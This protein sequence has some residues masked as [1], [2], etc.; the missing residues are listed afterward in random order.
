MRQIEENND[1]KLPLG[2]AKHA[3][4]GKRC[5]N[6]LDHFPAAIENHALIQRAFV[7]DFTGFQLRWFDFTDRPLLEIRIPGALRGKRFKQRLEF[8]DDR[9]VPQYIGGRSDTR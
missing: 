1:G 4:G 2:N 3:Q 5:I 8:L 7:R 9:F 6:V